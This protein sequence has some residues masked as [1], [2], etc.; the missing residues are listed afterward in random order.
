MATTDIYLNKT[1]T[2][3]CVEIIEETG[4]VNPYFTKQG[5]TVAGEFIEGET[6]ISFDK[7]GNSYAVEF[8]ER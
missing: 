8:I 3:E 2:L 1:G 7:N 5:N 6:D 4:C